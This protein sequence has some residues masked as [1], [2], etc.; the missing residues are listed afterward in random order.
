MANPG[1]ASI[2]CD[3]DLVGHR[4]ADD[5]GDCFSRTTSTVFVGPIVQLD[6]QEEPSKASR[7]T[8]A[9]LDREQSAPAVLK[10]NV[11]RQLKSVSVEPV[12]LVCAELFRRQGL[13]LDSSVTLLA[14]CPPTTTLIAGTQLPT[15]GR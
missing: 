7:L 6:S 5:A 14:G 11:E 12:G 8:T 2:T 3:Q 4:G 1:T 10:Q 15:A 13:G 9:I